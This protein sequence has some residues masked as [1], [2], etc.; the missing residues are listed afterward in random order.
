MKVKAIAKDVRVSPKKVVPIVK[1]VRGKSVGDALNILRFSPSPAAGVVAKV[2]KSAASNAENNYQMLP[3]ALR[4]VDIVADK[5]HVMK[6][7][8]PQA[9]GR[10][11][12][13]LKRSSHITVT[14]T[15]EE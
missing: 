12:P 6:R 9:R 4:I 3:A 13:I 8:R 5:G 10:A 11:N 15:E 1:A 2:I 14:V 7:F